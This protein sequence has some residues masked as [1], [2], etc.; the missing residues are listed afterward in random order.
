[1]K[2]A[3]MS[4][5]MILS[6][7]LLLAFNLTVFAAEPGTGTET[8][9]QPDV[10]DHLVK[11]EPG[12]DVSEANQHKIVSDLD[13]IESSQR[14]DSHAA[15]TLAKT[16]AVSATTATYATYTGVLAREGESA[17]LYPVYV[18][19][20]EILQAQLDLPRSEQLDYDLYLYELD[21][22]TNTPVALIDYSIYGTYFNNY[23]YGRSTI[24][25]NVGVNNASASEK[26]YLLEVHAKKGGSIN[27]PFYLTV[28]I[29]RVYDSFETDENA[30]H[31]Y[32]ITVNTGG[33]YLSSRSLNSI[34]DNDWYVLTVP[35]SRNYDAMNITLDS[36]SAA[37]GYRAEVYA[38]LS[39]NRLQ[40][41]TP[42]NNNVPLGTGSYYLR[43]Y[44]TGTYSETT[45]YT[46]ALTPVLRA[47]KIQITGFNSDGGPNDY[48]SYYYGKKYRITGRTFTVNG[49]VSTADNVPV[50]NTSVIVLW[51]NPYWSESSGNRTRVGYAN[52]N[53]AGEFSVTLSL[54]PSTGSISN[55]LPGP[56][57]FTH[58]YDICGVIAAVADNIDV[59]AQQEVYHFAYSIYGG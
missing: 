41:I 21:A 3:R 59:N 10:I 35:S 30:F 55:Y 24:S 54:P 47:E 27:D 20:G 29:S 51:E 25:E 15:R 39:D 9:N 45:N 56:I 22:S 11:A 2:A 50:A 5:V 33:S 49:K 48:P 6:L 4:M 43:V 1:M 23:S 57:S 38:V 34:V 19:A 37:K 28:A 46:L 8:A 17:Y 44:T 42:A 52:T 40:L 26:A 36:A 7:V 18:Q 58:Y 14:I 31:A 53:S 12:V 13:S 32:G 16:S